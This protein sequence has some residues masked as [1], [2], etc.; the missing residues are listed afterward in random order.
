MM[1]FNKITSS[2]LLLLVSIVSFAQQ[3][4]RPDRFPS[5]TDDSGD[6]TGRF[7]TPGGNQVPVD[8]YA[9]ILIGFAVLFIAYVVYT[10]KFQAKNA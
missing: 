2:A 5:N 9:Y 8:Q 7:A 1:N 10:R 6:L 4:E 3:Q